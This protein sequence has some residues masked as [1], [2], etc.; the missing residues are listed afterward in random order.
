[1]KKHIFAS[2]ACAAM[3]CSLIPVHQ[4]IASE[5]LNTGLTQQKESVATNPEN[6]E[7][8]EN[9]LNTWHEAKYQGFFDPT[10]T[11]LK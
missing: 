7:N 8:K 10:P 11:G 9:T 1:M 5:E 3:I 2:C 6:K 4:A